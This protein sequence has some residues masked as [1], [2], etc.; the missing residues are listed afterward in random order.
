MIM[1]LLLV[2]IYPSETEGICDSTTRCYD[3]VANCQPPC[4]A[5]CADGCY[6]AGTCAQATSQLCS[7]TSKEIKCTCS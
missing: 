2:A 3:T 1:S 6:A 7:N 4:D 5:Y